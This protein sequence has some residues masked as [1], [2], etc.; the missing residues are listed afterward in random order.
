M[1]A[2]EEEASPG[3]WFFLRS[4]TECGA[5]GGESLRWLETIRGKREPAVEIHYSLDLC[6]F[7]VITH[8]TT[9]FSVLVLHLQPKHT[10]PI[11][12]LSVSSHTTPHALASWFFTFSLN[13]PFFPISVLSCHHTRHHTL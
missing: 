12:V 2:E 3:G 9:R 8:D 5:D 4:L 1:E 7:R 10:F 13:T 11:F 6:S